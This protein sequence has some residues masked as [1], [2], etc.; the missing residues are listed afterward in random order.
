MGN[1]LNFL[2]QIHTHIV[3]YPQARC[4]QENRHFSE[5]KR[6]L[7]ILLSVCLFT[8][9]RGVN[10]HKEYTMRVCICKGKWRAVSIRI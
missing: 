4:K 1:G 7:F 6:N 9:Q 5:N 8:T 2:L 10:G 3:Y